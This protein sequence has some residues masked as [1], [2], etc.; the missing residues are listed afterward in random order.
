MVTPHELFRET[1]ASTDHDYIA[2]IKAI[3]VRF[4]LNLRQAKEVMIQSDGTADSLDEHEESL[5]SIVEL[6]PG[7]AKRDPGLWNVTPSG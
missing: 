2:A 4:G 5:I 7:C 3:R 1:V 6:F